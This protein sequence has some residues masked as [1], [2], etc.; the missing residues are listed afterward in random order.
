MKDWR[1]KRLV[2]RIF[3]QNKLN[4]KSSSNA[5]VDLWKSDVLKKLVLRVFIQNKLSTAINA[6]WFA[7]G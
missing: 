6:P 2:L 5:V 3:V 1:L 7:G 4:T